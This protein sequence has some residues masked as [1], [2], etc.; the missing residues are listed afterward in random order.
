MKRKIWSATCTLLLI[1]TLVVAQQNNNQ[2]LEEVITIGS[3][4]A[5][6][7]ITGSAHYIGPESLDKFEYSDIQRIS[8]E[9]PGVSIQIEDGYGLRP[10]ISIRGVA[11]E[12][13]GRITLLED[14][15]LIAPAPYSAPSAY[16]FPTAGRM[17]AFEV[18]KGPSAIT[19]GPYTIGG[20]LNMV[21][22][23]IPSEQEG[24][25]MLEYGEDATSRVHASYGGRSEN[26][27][28]YLLEAHQWKSDGF[29]A[30]DRSNTDTG[31]DVTDFT[32][33]LGYAPPGSAHAIELKLQKTTQNSNQSYLGLTDAD[34]AD[35][36]YRRYGLSE[37]DTIESD[38]DQAVLRY[39]FEWND[40]IS[41]SAAAYNNESG[42]NWFKT[43]GID[44]D[45]SD[46]AQE[47]SRTSWA[48]VI[49]AVNIG[50]GMVGG[51]RSFDS[52][53]LQAILDGD[54]DTERGSIQLRSNA[55]EYYSR[56]IQTQ[57]NL[58]MESG[59]AKH[60]IEL[61]LRYH[62]DEEDRLQRNSTYQQ[63]N[64]ELV[65]N[66]LGELGNAGNRVQKAEAV[67]FYIQDKIELGSWILTP[68]LRYESIDQIRTRYRGGANRTFRDSREN[69]T[70]VLLP[71][72]GAIY[73][74]T[75]Q[76]SLVAGI[77]KGFTAPSNSPGI[78]EEEAINT[79]FGIRFNSERLHAEV[80]AFSSDYDNLLG[81]CTSSSGSD[82]EI[83]D[84]F[85]GDAATVLGIEM[86]FA[87][88]LILGGDLQMPISFSYTFIDGE[89]DTDIADTDFF[90][91]VSAGDPI[92]HIP[93]NQF[94]ISIG[95]E[96]GNW[97][98]NSN[99]NYLD[100]V[101]T[102]ASCDEFE[103]TESALTLDV[104]GQYRL[105]DNIKLFARI[106]NLTDEQDI[107]G[108]QPY[109]A[110]PNKGRTASLG[111]EFDF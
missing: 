85:N 52:N 59:L 63:L 56:G 34:F 22:T 9:V 78:R 95:L 83:G 54:L 104:A 1:P 77:H 96:S 99:I 38:H 32:V 86:L 50:S 10:N 102:R 60:N 42:R 106:E 37:L 43:E 20:A 48:N 69:H 6:Q 67:A 3:R 35:S 16:Y 55:R 17:T 27:F 58:A 31:L 4:E 88:K 66:D 89:F 45:G 98:A 41:F 62:E 65:L 97:Q 93:E 53:Q 90:G 68:G 76:L 94:Q 72:F 100:E 92:P 8:R 13:S 40:K 81:E 7:T 15:I 14:N 111:L 36:A 64:G 105:Q 82:C 39:R 23:P 74:L 107:L 46:N 91:N 80:I 44:L 84:A 61:G 108:R 5:A 25:I 75:D 57:L 101:C 109:G 24:K 49:N 21:S 2:V 18:V 79:E 110:R 87:N 28:G 51:S 26:G 12:R 103:K 19:Q 33:K 29:Q 73:S 30:I 71:G 47:F 11:T 70:S